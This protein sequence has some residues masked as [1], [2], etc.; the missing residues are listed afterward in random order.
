MRILANIPDDDILEDC[1]SLIF[2]VEI[3]ELHERDKF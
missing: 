3:G 1:D 2:Q